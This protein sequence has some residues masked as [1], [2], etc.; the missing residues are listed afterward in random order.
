M[1]CGFGRG[2][3]CEDGIIVFGIVVGVDARDDARTDASD[4]MGIGSRLY[5]IFPS[6]SIHFL[7]MTFPQSLF[8]LNS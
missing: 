7:V 1:E 4:E 2:Y 6:H 8:R 5:I 3:G